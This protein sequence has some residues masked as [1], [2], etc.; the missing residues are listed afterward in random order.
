[1]L[2]GCKICNSGRSRSCKSNRFGHWP[3]T[4][5]ITSA[6]VLTSGECLAIIEEREMKK[7]AEEKSKERKKERSKTREV[8]EGRRKGMDG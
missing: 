5:A 1:M 8:E 4:R 7:K 3:K 2:E 6:R